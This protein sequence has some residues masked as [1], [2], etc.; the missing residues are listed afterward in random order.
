MNTFG[1]IYQLTTFG[2]SH[3]AAIGG[4]IDGVPSNFELDIDHIQNELN[5][6][7]PGQSEIVTQRNE[8]DH[9]EFLSGIYEGKT[10][11]TPIGFIIRNTDNH[12]TDYDNLRHIFR[13]G[14]ADFTYISKY[15]HRDHRGGGRSSARETAAR[16]VAGAIA[17]QILAQRHIKIYS[18]TSSVGNISLP[19]DFGPL[20]SETDII[21]SNIVRCPHS[22]TAASMAKLI[23]SVK[24]EGDT[25]GGIITGIIE[26]LPPTLGEPVFDKLQATLAHGMMSINAAKG[27][28]YGMG[29]DGSHKRGSEVIDYFCEQNASNYT[30]QSNHSGGIQGGISNGMPVVFR[31][32]FKPVA[33]LLKPITAL[34]DNGEACQ[35]KVK[36]R[37]DPCV[38]PRAVPIVDAMAAITILDALM[39]D[40]ARKITL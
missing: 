18:Y 35:L 29:F 32:A 21:D 28:E 19:N 1:K 4:I 12:S 3:G 38:V 20:I 25:I 22:E 36:G 37:H 14:H 5:R 2:E 6:R 33:T 9:V 13:P 11:G 17:K 30:T 27:F 15:A 39:I 26:G 8:S 31:V 16:V 7:R 24:K 40:H 23:A 34:S 10:L